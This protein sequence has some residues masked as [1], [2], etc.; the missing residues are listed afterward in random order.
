MIA[1]DQ[2]WRIPTSVPITVVS[3]GPPALRATDEDEE[4]E[5]T[6]DEG[7]EV[8]PPAETFEDDD[9]DDE[10]DDD[11]EEEFEGADHD[12]AEGEEADE[13]EFEE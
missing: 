2:P 10:F 5:E 13:D 8:I 12:E 1:V 7:M 3:A 4:I 6:D 11:F 9:F